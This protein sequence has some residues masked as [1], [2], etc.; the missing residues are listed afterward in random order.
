MH[1]RK[2]LD[3]IK[4][5]GKPIT[6]EKYIDLCLYG[7]NGYYKKSNILGKK[8]DFTTAPEI[9]QLFGEIIGL[10]ILDKWNNSIKQEFN[11]IELGP[12]NGTLILDILRITKK[13]INFNQSLKI[14]LIEKN[15]NLKKKQKELLSNID[16]NNKIK[17]SE[18]FNLLSTKPTIILAN[19]FFDCLPIRQFY[20]NNSQWYE[21]MIKFKQNDK[22]L[23]YENKLINN[24]KI[25]HI[26]KKNNP[27]DI[28]ELSISREKYFTKMCTHIS[29]V[30]GFIFIVDYGYLEEPSNF[31]L[32]SMQNNKKTNILD[33]IGF[34]DIT[35]LVDFNKFLF[36]AKKKGLKINTFCSQRDFL[37]KYGIFERAKKIS[38][39]A[40]QRQKNI[41][42]Q[43][44]ERVIDIN[45][46]GSS[47]KVLIISK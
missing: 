18:N 3:E 28:F 14:H 7:K 6:I 36:I 20:K 22:A 26:L 34:Q 11:L 33:N 30:G 40:S 47:F 39:N 8:G 38:I 4:K 29:N 45:R 12:G 24:K 17:W 9:S 25:L 5:I 44:L 23:K 32:Q 15:K 19:E 46:M 35:S 43:G 13:F 2:I 37:I 21:K 16:L 42:N 27:K 41:I 10:F 1:E 31:T